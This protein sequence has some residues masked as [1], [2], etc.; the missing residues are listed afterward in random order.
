MAKTVRK[1]RKKKS[2]RK[3]GRKTP[4]KVLS[5]GAKKTVR[6]PVATK[7]RKE[8][9]AKKPATGRSANKRT[10]SKAASG[11]ESSRTGPATNEPR[12]S[13]APQPGA[14]STGEP[15]LMTAPPSGVKVRM[16]RQ[17]HGDCFLLA[18]AG[19]NGKPVYVLI[20]CGYK[21]GSNGEKYGLAEIE[22]IVASIRAATGG[23]LDL[24]VITH[25]HQDHV[26]GFWKKTDPYFGDFTVGEAWFA[27]TE[28]P[29]DDLANELRRR[30]HDQL[31]GLVAAR[32]QLAAA[33]PAAVG[34]LDD[35]LGLELGV[36]QPSEF[37][38]A[39]ANK[40]KDPESSVNK[41]GMKL[42]KDKATPKNTKYIRPHKEIMKIPRVDGVRIYALGPPYDADLIADEDPQ[43]SEAFPGNPI[44]A[45]ASFF[46]A[47]QVTNRDDAD[48]IQ[49]FSR[50]FAVPLA[51]AFKNAPYADFFKSR[52]GTKDVPVAPA[53][54]ADEC[55][56]NPDWRRIDTDW[57]YSAEE[58][59]LVV[60]KGINNTSLVLAFELEK[61]KKVLMFVGDAQRG[62]WKSWTAGTWKDGDNE[63]TVRDLMARTVLYK[64]G[65]HGSHNATLN[66]TAASDYPCLAWMGLGKAGS[67]FTAMITAVHDWAYAVKPKPWR[68]PLPSI[69]AALMQKAANRVFQ[70]DTPQVSAP[71]NT[72]D[73][74]WQDFSRRTTIDPNGLYF[75][76]E[77]HD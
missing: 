68:H 2:P 44:S 18:F 7:A 55:A 6:K 5:R 64:V 4:K 21:P 50:R 40:K 77:V 26:N 35:L 36:T 71:A 39:A 49:P 52:Y 33:G 60:N 65:H 73:P 24:V 28:D 16:Y 15:G 57:L 53:Q 54:F 42:I 48:G 34:L 8:S 67:E 46:A 61:S 63:I 56:T 58:L 41:Q 62:N 45:R 74:D 38:S 72:S 17:G 22:D 47:A 30:Y 10:L 25:E 19:Q 29:K 75:E 70:I 59:A 3:T 37:A 14:S 31:L 43:D 69:K 20:D 9:G 23:H 13:G 32:N 66:G 76:Y 27:W 11:K 51:Q 1:S 12:R